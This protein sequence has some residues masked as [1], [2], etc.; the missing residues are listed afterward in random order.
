[1]AS[2]ST[3]TQCVVNYANE[4][5]VSFSFDELC[6]PSYKHTLC[7]VSTSNKE[8]PISPPC[9]SVPPTKH[10]TG[11]QLV[12]R[13]LTSWSPDQL[14]TWPAGHLTSWRSCVCAARGGTLLPLNVLFTGQ[15]DLWPRRLNVSWTQIFHEGASHEHGSVAPNIEPRSRFQVSTTRRP[16]PS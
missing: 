3:G 4:L 1:M 7:C 8:R 11:G 10:L 12:A 15:G 9:P 13:H 2:A 5:C 6:V 16:H 14:V